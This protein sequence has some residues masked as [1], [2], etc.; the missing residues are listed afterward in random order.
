MTGL[1]SL[2]ERERERE[3]ERVCHSLVHKFTMN[4]PTNNVTVD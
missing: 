2:R 1:D 3:R 4:L